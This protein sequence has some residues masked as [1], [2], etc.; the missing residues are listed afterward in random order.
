MSEVSI[1]KENASA[2]FDLHWTLS[3]SNHDREQEEP[4][5]ERRRDMTRIL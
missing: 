3:F 2:M 1:I 4:R 5:V